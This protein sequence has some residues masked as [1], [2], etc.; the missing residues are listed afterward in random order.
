[1]NPLLKEGIGRYYQR[2]SNVPERDRILK[3]MVEFASGIRPT[4]THSIPILE[5]KA[6]ATASHLAHDSD[7]MRL[8]DM[9]DDDAAVRAVD[10]PES[11]TKQMV[12][13]HVDKGMHS[14]YV[15]WL[16]RTY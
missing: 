5:G 4:H 14:A 15:P 16:E 13:R 3:E 9:F 7:E 2:A 1:M 12:R 8:W 10:I 6:A 11:P